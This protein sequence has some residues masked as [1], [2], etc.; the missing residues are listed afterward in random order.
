MTDDTTWT[1]LHKNPAI[2]IHNNF[3]QRDC[4]TFLRFNDTTMHANQ[5][6]C[7]AGSFCR[8]G[9]KGSNSVIANVTFDNAPIRYDDSVVILGI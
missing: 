9:C 3:W 2:L 7:L 6:I 8:K 5:D 1:Y 4:T